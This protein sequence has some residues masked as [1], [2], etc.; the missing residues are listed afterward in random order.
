[1]RERKEENKRKAVAEVKAMLGVLTSFL[2]SL[3]HAHKVRLDFEGRAKIKFGDEDSDEVYMEI[4]RYYDG[5][6]ARE[7]QR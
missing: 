2:C 6:Y 7:R 1:M 5:F 4:E 3:G